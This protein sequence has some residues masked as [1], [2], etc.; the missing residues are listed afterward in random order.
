MNPE[1]AVTNGAQQNNSTSLFNALKMPVLAA[2]L[3]SLASCT[4]PGGY[5]PQSHSDDR[6]R[7]RA[8][9]AGAAREDILQRALSK[10]L[11]DA[12]RHG[13]VGRQMDLAEEMAESRYRERQFR[14][15]DNATRREDRYRYQ[16]G[17][18]LQSLPEQ[19]ANDFVRDL[20]REARGNAR[21]LL[22]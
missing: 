6:G 20:V 3:F 8:V 19:L 13:D 17:S 4:V 16:T 18:S 5:M 22:R 14:Y 1:P 21:R 12:R 9:G 7:G 15:Q 11:S 2:A 10:E